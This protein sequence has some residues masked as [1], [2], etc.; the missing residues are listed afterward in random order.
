MTYR[1]DLEALRART[2]ALTVEVAE[3]GRDLAATRGLLDEAERRAR[4]PILD[5]IRVASPCTAEWGAMTGDERVR[6]CGDCHKRVYNLSELTREEA[7]ALVVEHEGKLC[8]RFFQRADGTILLRDCSIGV[9]RNRRRKIIAG[10]AAIVA[11]S[12]VAGAFASHAPVAAIAKPAV[13]VTLGQMRVAAPT[14]PPP[15]EHL[16]EVKGGATWEPEVV[17]VPSKPAKRK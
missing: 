11:G 16:Y 3:R 17:V 2:Q 12:G 4:L 9:R 14:P 13:T 15:D 10:A 6:S 1:D 5:N 8:V 7:Q